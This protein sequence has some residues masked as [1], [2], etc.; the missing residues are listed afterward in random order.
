MK[1]ILARVLV[2]VATMGLASEAQAHLMVAN[3]GTVSIKGQ[4]AY[5]VMSV[6]VTALSGF[7]DNQDTLIDTAE[8][9][10]HS[11]LLRTQVD[12]RLDITAD[13][14]RPVEDVTFLLSPLTGDHADSPIDYLVVMRAARFDSQPRVIKVWTDLFGSAEKDRR[15]ALVVSNAQVEEFAVLT[16]DRPRHEFFRGGIAVFT[17]FV[18]IGV[19]HILLGYDHLLFLLVVVAATVGLRQWLWV[20]T[21]FTIAHSITI[22]AASLGWVSVS[23]QIVEPLIA[24]SIVGL[25]VD[26]MLGGTRRPFMLRMVVVFACGLLH[27]LGFAASLADYGLSDRNIVGSLLGFNLGVEF[28]Q[29]LFVSTVLISFWILSRSAALISRERLVVP[30]SLLAAAPGLA[31]FVTRAF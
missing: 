7:D 2:L 14:L 22:S 20:I 26:N 9:G 24:A 29:M 25:A 6:P 31:L 17:D 13:G 4:N 8:L 30:V 28:G 10:R 27:G 12:S 16:P 23:P 18:G 5:V 19:T 11:A 1:R 21:C 3:T 15:L